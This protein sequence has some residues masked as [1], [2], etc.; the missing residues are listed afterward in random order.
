MKET[1]TISPVIIA[2]VFCFEI[3]FPFSWDKVNAVKEIP[4]RWYDPERKSWF[5]T[6]DEEKSLIQFLRKFN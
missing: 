4:G 5:I 2:D 3:R 6:G 1:I